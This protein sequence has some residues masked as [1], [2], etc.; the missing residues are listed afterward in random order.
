M[1]GLLSFL[2]FSLNDFFN[3]I[4]DVQFIWFFGVFLATSYLLLNI[5]N[6]FSVAIFKSSVFIWLHLIFLKWYSLFDIIIVVYNS[7]NI[8]F[9]FSSPT[10]FNIWAHS[11]K[12]LLNICFLLFCMSQFLLKTGQFRSCIVAATLIFISSHL[13]VIIVDR[14]FCFDLFIVKCQEHTS[15]I[16]HDTD[17][18]FYVSLFWSSFLGVVSVSA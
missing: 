8:I 12:F 9:F 4:W 2:D 17:V 7:V 1:W 10:Q 11:E 14:V 15:G 16:C 3:V 18:D 13:K 6:T 5:S